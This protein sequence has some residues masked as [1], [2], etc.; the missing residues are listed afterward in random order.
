MPGVNYNDVC[1]ILG[2]TLMVDHIDPLCDKLFHRIASDEDHRLNSLLLPLYKNP[3]YNLRNHRL[4]NLPHVRTN[5]PKNSFIPAMA[6]EQIKF[7][8]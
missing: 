5:R 4:Y 7:Y 1:E 8:R 3:R 6:A 2:I